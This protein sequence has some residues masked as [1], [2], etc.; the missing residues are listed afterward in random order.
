MSPAQS[1]EPPAAR[2]FP[3]EANWSG[4]RGRYISLVGHYISLV[5]HFSNTLR[6][7][8]TAPLAVT[9]LIGAASVSERSP[10]HTRPYLVRFA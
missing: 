7:P 4:R 1:R 9:A 3:G 8:N 5:G 10:W 6:C 2:D